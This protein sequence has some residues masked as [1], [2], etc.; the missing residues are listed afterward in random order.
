[1]RIFLP[2]EL[3][4]STEVEEKIILSGKINPA[5]NIKY[6]EGNIECQ[7]FSHVIF[8]SVGTTRGQ[9]IVRV[10]VVVVVVL[11]VATFFDM[12]IFLEEY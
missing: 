7:M 2:S 9:R 10:T 3:T 12:L 1:M 8:T 6:K 5:P 11:V 4:Q